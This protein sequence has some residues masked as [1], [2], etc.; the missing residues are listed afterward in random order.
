LLSRLS[1][2]PRF[3]IAALVLAT[4]GF[5]LLFAGHA[6][7]APA[8]FNDN[9]SCWGKISKGVPDPDVAAVPVKYS[10]Q[11]DGRLTGYSILTAPE[12]QVQGADTEV[13]VTDGNGAVVG[14]DSF[15]CNGTYP[16]Y[17]I[18]CVSPAGGDYKTPGNFVTGQFYVDKAICAEP[19]LDPILYIA[20]ATGNAKLQ[21][22]QSLAGPFDLGQPLGCPKPKPHKTHTKRK[23]P[24]EQDQVLTGQEDSRRR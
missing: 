2:R 24:I 11:C 3:A 1:P 5:A 4:L 16:G 12:R 22:L 14:T 20:Y 6:T 9:T 15:S 19:R 21:G 23:I 10:F 13:F 18:N 7:K 17:G 8:D